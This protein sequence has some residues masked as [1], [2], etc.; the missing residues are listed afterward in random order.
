[1]S[2]DAEQKGIDPS[3]EV[4]ADATEDGAYEIRV[5]RTGSTPPPA[6]PAEP[7][8]DPRADRASSAPRPAARSSRRPVVGAVV[9]AAVVL[10]GSAALV[11]GRSHPSDDGVRVDELEMEPP[12]SFQVYQ[13]QP[14]ERA[15]LPAFALDAG[16]PGLMVQ[17]I[18]APGNEGATEGLE[19]GAE[20]PWRNSGVVVPDPAEIIR[21]EDLD[22]VTQQRLQEVEVERI[23][24]TPEREEF[25]RRAERMDTQQLQRP[26]TSGTNPARE[27]QRSNTPLPPPLPEGT[28]QEY[29]EDELV[30]DEDE[31]LDEPDDEDEYE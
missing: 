10:A 30:D 1:M 27:L 19:G 13:V 18:V 21:F 20:N 31:L 16:A 3:V 7:G 17:P 6:E 23:P 9:G 14:V 15:T 22:P 26:G 29:D 28:V 8:D 11:L 24:S 25:L 4:V 2:K 5:R 12:P